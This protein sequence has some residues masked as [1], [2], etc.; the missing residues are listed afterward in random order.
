M[1]Q[2]LYKVA[3]LYNNSFLW[4]SVKFDKFYNVKTSFKFCVRVLHTYME[5]RKVGNNEHYP[6]LPKIKMRNSFLL[7]SSPK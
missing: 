1:A 5:M 3:S 2:K 6:P 7:M 4:N